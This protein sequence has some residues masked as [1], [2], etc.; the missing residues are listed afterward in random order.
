MSTCCEPTTLT[1]KIHDSLN[2]T[3][4]S[5]GLER[6]QRWSDRNHGSI[7]LPSIPTGG[8]QPH[9]TGTLGDARVVDCIDRK[10]RRS[11]RHPGTNSGGRRPP[12]TARLIGCGR[13]DSHP[14]THRPAHSLGSGLS[15][16]FD[17]PT[18]SFACLSTNARLIVALDNPTDDASSRQL[19]LRTRLLAESPIRTPASDLGKRLRFCRCAKNLRR[20]GELR[21]IDIEDFRP[22]P[23]RRHAREVNRRSRP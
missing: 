21:L 8:G 17:A 16:Q 19:I 1:I 20:Q 12:F 10:K 3:R 9:D 2:S 14:E 11:A 23:L 13:L 6:A 22:D 15:A 18:R 7:G 5:L 4:A